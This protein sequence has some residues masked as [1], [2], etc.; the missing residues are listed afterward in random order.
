MSKPRP[1]H[2]GAT[3]LITRR[4]ERRHCLLRPDSAMT[5]FIL[6]AFIVSACRHGIQLHAF[7]AMSTHLHYVVSDPRGKLPSF[8]EMFHRLVALGVKILR[9]WDGSPW[10]RAQ[11]SVVELCTRE[12][13]VEKIAYTLANP[14][15]AGL[16]RH[17]HEWPGAK[18]MVDDIG[19]GTIQAK[20][21]DIYFS[22]KN[23]EWVLDAHLAVTLPPSLSVA[24][25]QAFRDDIAIELAKLEAAAHKTIPER[26]ILGPIQAIKV[27]PETRVMTIEPIRQHNPTF[28][29]GRGNAEAARIAA[30]GVRSFR[31]AYRKALEAWRAGDRAVVFPAGTYGMR[32]FHGANIGPT[33]RPDLGEHNRR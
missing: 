32:V 20:R 1:I 29:V 23:P 24:D 11:T 8:L 7:C 3:Y 14:V 15:E 33:I 18:T 6:F 9:K 4:T 19:I 28:A 17:A 12:A 2:P 16:V 26:A 21:P 10:D 27:P 22:P 13:I 25:L 31:A 30:R 5:R